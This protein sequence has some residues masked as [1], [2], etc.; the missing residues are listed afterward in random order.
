MIG[1]RNIWATVIAI[2]VFVTLY[3]ILYKILGFELAVLSIL[4]M[5]TVRQIEMKGEDRR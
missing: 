1:D 2:L 4:V 3:Y 5:I